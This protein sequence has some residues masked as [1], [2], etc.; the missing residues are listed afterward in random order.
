MGKDDKI[1]S[2]SFEEH[3]PDSDRHEDNCSCGYDGILEDFYG[4]R[5]QECVRL[6]CSTLQP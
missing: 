5:R 1:S 6:G 4:R 3:Y 2:V